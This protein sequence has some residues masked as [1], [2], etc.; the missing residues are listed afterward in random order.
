MSDQVICIY[1]DWSVAEDNR[2]VPAVCP[3]RGQVYTIVGEGERNGNK[4]YALWE[5]PLQGG[6]RS[7]WLAEYFRKCRPTDISSLT[8][9]RVM[10]P[11]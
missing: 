2:P 4:F 9:I 10:E 7:F 11:A 8:N 3:V 1:D 5:M 6:K